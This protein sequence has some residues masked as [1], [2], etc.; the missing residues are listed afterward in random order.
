MEN[1]TKIAQTITEMGFDCDCVKGVVSPRFEIY[2]FKLK[3]PYHIN[4]FG[5]KQ[6]KVLE[7]VYSTRF[8]FDN[9]MVDYSFSIAFEHKDFVLPFKFDKPNDYKHEWVYVGKDTQNNDVRLDFYNETKHL[10]IG[11]TTGAGKSSFIHSIILGLVLSGLNVV[12]KKGH[13]TP[14]IYLF[15]PKKVEFSKYACLP[16]CSV[17]I[18]TRKIAEKLEMLVGVMEQRLTMLEKRGYTDYKEMNIPALFIFI[19]ELADLVMCGEPTIEKNITRLAQLG[20]S[21]GIH[22]IIAT[23]NPIAKVLTSLIK[24]NMTTRIALQCATK[25]SSVVMLDHIG[26]EKLLGKGDALLK[27]PSKTTEVRLQG[28]YCSPERVKEL[29]N[30]AYSNLF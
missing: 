2:Y 7:Q 5:A 17:E 12:D 25:M 1:G 8:M 21:A 4:M 19:D 13:T 27:L 24:A 30:L 23:Q 10:L 28:C 14:Y 6:I 3:N 22:L 9:N 11:G 18:D 20:R 15:D 26:A 16:C 29:I